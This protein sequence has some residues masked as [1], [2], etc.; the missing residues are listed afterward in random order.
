MD[1]ISG[2]FYSTPIRPTPPDCHH[3]IEPDNLALNRLILTCRSIPRQ[4]FNNL[5]YSG[6]IKTKIKSCFH[7]RLDPDTSLSSPPAKHH[8]YQQHPHIQ[9]NQQ[10]HHHQYRE[11]QHKQSRD[12]GDPYY[13]VRPE[14]RSSTEMPRSSAEVTLSRDTEILKMGSESRNFTLSPVSV[15]TFFMLIGM[16]WA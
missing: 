15:N 5:Y 14:V 9:H 13:T 8:Q 3:K 7:G 6:K 4:L 12:D 11:P 2:N 10:P 1:R 16:V